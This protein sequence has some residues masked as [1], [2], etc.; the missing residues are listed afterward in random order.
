[1]IGYCLHFVHTCLGKTLNPGKNA[2]LNCRT[3]TLWSSDKDDCRDES[4]DKGDVQL[5]C[6]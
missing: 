4:T 1:M 3:V 6:A 5:V 2:H